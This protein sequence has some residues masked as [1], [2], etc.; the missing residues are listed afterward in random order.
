MYMYVCMCIYIYIY[1]YITYYLLLQHY[2]MLGS[3]S[4]TCLCPVALS[5]T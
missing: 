5:H 4:S 3:A 1:I 2:D